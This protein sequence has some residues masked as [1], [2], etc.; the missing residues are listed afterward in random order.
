MPA[1]APL[2]LAPDRLLP[3][4]P[5]VRAG[6]AAAV[7]RG[8]G[9]A[10]P[11]AARSRRRPA[12][13]RRRPVPRP[14]QPAGHA[15]PLRDPAAARRRGPARRPGRRARDRLPETRVP[16]RSGGCCARTGTCSAAPRRATGSRPSWPTS[17]ASTVRPSAQTADALYDQIAER[18]AKDDYRPARPVRAVRHRGAGHDRR[19]VRRPGRARGP[20]RG[21]RL[22]RP[23]APDVPA[24]PV[25]GAGR[26][27]WADGG[28]RGSA[29]SAASTP[30]ATPAGSRR[31]RTA[32]AYFRR[33]APSRPTTAT[34][35]SAPSRWPP[36][37]AERI[38]RAALT[39]H[40]RPPARPS[41]CAGT[42]C[43][44]WPGCPATTAW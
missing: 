34:R 26:A 42:C 8:P 28:R 37:E 4:D 18:L 23:G 19:P 39:G 10:D 14:G 36:A 9:P 3:A 11:L 25:P 20:G 21:P 29:R 40:G 38:Y 22:P 24:G 5:G 17:S 15:R 1:P 31:W 41:R 13:G 16:R 7:R 35:T 30:A 27:G 2:V 43:W 12:A 44:R 32:G 6:R 33:T